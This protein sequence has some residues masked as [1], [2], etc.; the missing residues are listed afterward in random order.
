LWEAWKQQ[1]IQAQTL[2]IPE[3]I[4]LPLHEMNL[5]EEYLP[6]LAKLGLEIER[7]GTK[8]FLVRSVPLLLG[9]L[10]VVSLIQELVQDL[11]EWKST[12]SLEKRVR[13]VLASFACQGAVQAG[14][15][16]TAPE[17]KHLITDWVHAGSPMT[18]PHGRRIA[19]CF[20]SDEL[21]GIFGRASV[22]V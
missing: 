19:L 4:D 21:N 20:S 15:T 10:N 6:E 1:A 18:C 3:H 22:S 9:N 5:L 14:R 7:F 12:E 16:M 11:S 8:T 13:T 2:L 17:I